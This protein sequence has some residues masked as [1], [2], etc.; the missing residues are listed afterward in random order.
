MLSIISETTLGIEINEY[1]VL[2]A[3]L[4]KKS[5]TY[6]LQRIVQASIPL[7]VMSSEG[8]I[9]QVETL[10]NVIRETMR[11][12]NIRSNKAHLVVPSQYVVIRQLQ[13]P[14]VPEPQ[15]R[16]VIDFELQNSIHLP[17]EDPVYDVVKTGRA[18]P[19]VPVDELSTEK[20]GD[21]KPLANVALIAS[22]R[23]VIDPIVEAAKKAGL[24]P[25]GVDI[26][27]LALSRTCSKLC[28]SIPRQTTMFVD[29]AEEWTD[30]HIFDGE[31]LQ[32]T[33]NVPMQ[34][35]Q[36]RIDRELQKPLHVLEILEYFERNTD[37][38]SFTND[39]GYEIERSM[40][41]YRYTLNNRDA[42]LTGIIVS[43]VLPKTGVLQGYL[44][45]RFVDIATTTMPLDA[46][47]WTEEIEH[48][49]EIVH[50][51]AIP[52]GLALKEVK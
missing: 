52:I 10:A 13:L 29:I 49:K 45:E 38:R 37:F 7:G 32:F 4:R 8:K 48:L 42:T 30:I 18:T 50:E 23:S 34:L 14:D 9:V 31:I 17:F 1:R 28:P 5:G 25:A 6:T 33:R 15:L 41:F 46:L 2:I 40:N 22:S 16:K 24:K 44:Q 39:L 20:A 3:E 35:E 19:Q 36:Y 26:R 21:N 27:A 43:G 47:Q 12:H 51:Y 11:Q